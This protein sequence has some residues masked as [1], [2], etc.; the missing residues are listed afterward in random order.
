MTGSSNEIQKTEKASRR[1]DIG[2]QA[3]RIKFNN[4]TICLKDEGTQFLS[5]LKIILKSDCYKE[6][7]TA[8]LSMIRREEL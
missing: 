2:K 7:S 6:S 5:N 4:M 8:Y 3:S 1:N